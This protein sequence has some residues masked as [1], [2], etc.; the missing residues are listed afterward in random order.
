[1]FAA[2][3]LLIAGFLLLL[4]R[5]A[6]R[7]PVRVAAATSAGM[8]ALAIGCIG[9][10][11]CGF[12]F[13]TDHVS[14]WRNE[15]LLLFSPLWLLTLPLWWAGVRGR[16]AVGVLARSGRAA[17]LIALG[18]A[19]FALAAKAFRGFPQGN[20]EWCLLMLPI[21]AALWNASRRT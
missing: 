14:A 9:L 5:F 8:L 6:E 18:L 4:F 3:G 11:L 12:W 19:I 2:S 10:V 16:P 1:L 20:L 15:N 13:G 17:A 7:A 21:V